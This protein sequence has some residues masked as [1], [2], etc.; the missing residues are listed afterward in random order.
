VPIDAFAG[1]THI[2]RNV[3]GPVR[4]MSAETPVP[5]AMLADIKRMA[6]PLGPT[7]GPRLS[8]PSSGG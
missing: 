5:K 1:G 6:A 7:L 4:I 3:D 2:T 8:V